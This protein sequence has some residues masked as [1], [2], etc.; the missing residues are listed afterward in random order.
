MPIVKGNFTFDVYRKPVLVSR[1]DLDEQGGNDPA[2]EVQALE[3]D[4]IES[5]LLPFARWKYVAAHPNVQNREVRGSLKTEY[6]ETFMRLKNGMSVTPQQTTVA[7]VNL[8]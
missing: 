3:P 5:Y 6:D 7:F 4:L 1:A 8:R 2:K